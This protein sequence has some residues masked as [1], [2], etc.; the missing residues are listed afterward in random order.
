MFAKEKDNFKYP[1]GVKASSSLV[2]QV[3]DNHKDF[4]FIWTRYLARLLAEGSVK[5]HPFEVVPGGLRGV[6]TGLQNL[7]NG[8][9]S[10]VKYVYRIADTEGI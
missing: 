5:P 9:A 8:K 7:M 2:L 6:A 4:G 3:H 10:A 1:S